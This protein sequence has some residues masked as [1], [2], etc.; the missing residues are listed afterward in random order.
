VLGDSYHVSQTP[1]DLIDK[2]HAAKETEVVHCV[3][4]SGRAGQFIAAQCAKADFIAASS[5]PVQWIR[6]RRKCC[7]ETSEQ[8][9]C[10]KRWMKNFR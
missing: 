10:A 4:D 7:L 3:A 8:T 5:D 9:L 6:S 2:P 1:V